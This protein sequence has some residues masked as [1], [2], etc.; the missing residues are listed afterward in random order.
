MP[1]FL[2]QGGHSMPVTNPPRL[3]PLL[4]RQPPLPW[5]CEKIRNLWETRREGTPPPMIRK[6]LR[7][8]L[9][10]GCPHRANFFTAPLRR[11]GFS[12]SRM[13]PACTPNMKNRRHP[14]PLDLPLTRFARGENLCPP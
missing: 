2:S 5:G 10:A 11:R 12:E 3:P 1:R 6:E 13:P 9:E 8:L 7:A 14:P 4:L